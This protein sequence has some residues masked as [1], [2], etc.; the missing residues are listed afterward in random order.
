[1]YLWNKLKE[2]CLRAKTQRRDNAVAEELLSSRLHASLKCSNSHPQTFR[3]LPTVV[4]R[5]V[6]FLPQHWFDLLHES[7]AD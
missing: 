2:T 3:N 4:H 5:R 6:Y 1:M 7:A